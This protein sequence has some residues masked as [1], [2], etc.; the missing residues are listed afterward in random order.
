M[1]IPLPIIVSILGFVFSVLMFVIGIL[2]SV[3]NK[4]TTAINEMKVAL[5]KQETADCYEEKACSLKHDYITKKLG[6]LSDT[7]QTHELRLVKLE[8]K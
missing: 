6:T 5:A 7:A 2:I 1:N 8:A 3:L 4:N